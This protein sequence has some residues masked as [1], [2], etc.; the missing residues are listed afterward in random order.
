MKMFI[1]NSKYY[2]FFHKCLD[3][4]PSHV[5]ISTFGIYA[6]LT[7][8]GEDSTEWGANYALDSRDL[9]EK[10]RALSNIRFLV[11]VTNYKSCKEKKPCVD[12]EKQY[13]KSLLRIGFHTSKFPEFDWKMTTEL[14]LKCA[15]FFYDDDCDP[16]LAKGIGGGRNFTNSNWVD[17]SFELSSEHISELHDHVSDLWD[18]S[19]TV[20]DDNIAV[21]L[22]KQRISRE[23]FE[24]I[25]E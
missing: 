23:G 11:G 24:A 21:I 9:I 2:E 14:H 5:F 22:G 10:M 3:A 8:T 20:N 1:P 12:C 25:L 7:F 13:V 16:K 4:D 15:L 17:A 19:L 6:G 18:E